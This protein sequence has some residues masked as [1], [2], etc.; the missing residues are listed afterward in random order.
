MKAY[1]RTLR[2]WHDLIASWKLTPWFGENYGVVMEGLFQKSQRIRWIARK[3]I[4]CVR[5][6]ILSRRTVG[7]VDLHTVAEI[8][9]ESRITVYDYPT[10]SCYAFHTNTLEK[11]IVVN[12]SYHTYGIANPQPPKN[13]YTNVPFSLAQNLSILQQIGRNL[14][15]WNRFLPVKLTRW[16]KARCCIQRL[17]HLFYRTLQVDA[18]VTFLKS[19]TEGDA[20]IIFRECIDD[21]YEL[22]EAQGRG[23]MC[24]YIKARRLPSELMVK[25]DKLVLSYWILHNHNIGYEEVQ[26][27]DDLEEL[28]HAL[29]QVSYAWWSTH[30]RRI[31]RRV[32][33]VAV[34]MSP[35]LAL[36]PNPALNPAQNLL[37]AR[38]L[39]NP[40]GAPDAPLERGSNP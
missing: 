3:W 40:V 37:V 11:M 36:A 27:M 24:S 2:E 20:L 39:P 34:A 22:V 7:L 15:Q 33:L 31:L 38:M 30:E 32:E 8:P 13:P 26:S 5:M 25:W 1:D 28:L 18:A 21:L 6:R 14:T 19:P 35:I 10:R 9:L 17:S 12:L 23:A 16:H 29:H 4:R